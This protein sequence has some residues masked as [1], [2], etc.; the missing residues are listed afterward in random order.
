[1]SE[2]KKKQ[3][4]QG[5]FPFQ[6]FVVLKN[7]DEV[8]DGEENRGEVMIGE[9]RRSSGLEVFLEQEKRIAEQGKEQEKPM[10]R[11]DEGQGQLKEQMREKDGGTEG[12]LD[13]LKNSS[14]TDM[15]TK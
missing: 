10:Q 12:V 8:K 11:R 2:E 5:D 14:E 9:K 13:H 7:E 4:G 6:N 15:P 1:M 3:D